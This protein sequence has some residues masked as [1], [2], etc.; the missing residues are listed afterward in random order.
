MDAFEFLDGTLRTRLAHLLRELNFYKVEP[1]KGIIDEIFSMDVGDVLGAASLETISKYITALSQYL[2]FLNYKRNLTEV[3][4]IFLSKKLEKNILRG[5]GTITS[6]TKDEKRRRFIDLNPELLELE[7]EVEYLNAELALTEDIPDSVREYINALKRYKDT[8]E[9][10]L[11][12]SRF[13]DS[14]G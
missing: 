10:E 1:N 13:E 12:S 3:K 4:R 2:I 11:K 9:F 5:L 7:A 14:N 6:G 8:K